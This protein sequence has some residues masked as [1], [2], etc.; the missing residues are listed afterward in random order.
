MSDLSSEQIEALAE[1]VAEK[2]L[3]NFLKL[4]GADPANINHIRD[5]QLDFI[6]MRKARIG[7]EE[8]M[9]LAKRTAI[10]VFITSALALLA[11]G[12]KQW[13]FGG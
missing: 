2:N 13:L 7:S 4:F 5:L 12:F 1:K 6:Y 8:A 10:G 11:A 3:A 9:L